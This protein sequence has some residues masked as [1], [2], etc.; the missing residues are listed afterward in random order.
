MK[1]QSPF[2]K[3]CLFSFLEYIRIENRIW[4]CFCYYIFRI[5]ITLQQ[6]YIMGWGKW[7][8]SIIGF[9]N[10]GFLGGLAGYCIG[11]FIDDAASASAA[12]AT[13]QRYTSNQSYQNTTYD[14]SNQRDS[15]LFSLMVLSSYI[16]K[17]DGKVM[18]SE[19]EYVR[20]FLRSNFGE[21]SVS[22]GESIL[23][24]LFERQKQE[25]MASFRNEIRG[26]CY[27][28]RSHF[29]ISLRLELL[30]FLVNIAKADGVVSP[31]E[32]SAL[33]EVG[34]YMGISEQEVE[35]MLHLS[36]GGSNE[37]SLDD[38]YRVLEISSSATDDEV[39]AAYR[40]MALK[41][42]PDRVASLGEDIRKAAEKKFQ[43]IN[44]AK[45]RIYKARGMA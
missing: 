7:I 34:S 23:L 27:E 43:E 42:H 4:H 26:C 5:L 24:R 12:R 28:I 39:K 20:G 33:K 32:V 8:G 45:E 18:H 41:H 35:S 6:Y 14:Q 21:V 9:A 1:R 19:M 44:N 22:Q 37:G 3:P 16:I 36:R 30:H 25:G 10:W 11:K 31:E 13:D 15:F 17:A 29:N 38:A 40:K 2:E